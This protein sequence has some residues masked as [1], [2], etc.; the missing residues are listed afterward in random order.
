MNVEKREVENRAKK[1]REIRFKDEK[2]EGAG[3]RENE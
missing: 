2:Y 1:R 3:G